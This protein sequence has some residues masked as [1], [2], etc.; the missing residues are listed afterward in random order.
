MENRA[1]I[2][3]F[4]D[5]ANNNNNNHW[6]SRKTK[7]RLSKGNNNMFDAFCGLNLHNKRFDFY[8]QHDLAESKL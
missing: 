2:V 3:V 7:R 4:S 6:L 8:L 1:A 5:R